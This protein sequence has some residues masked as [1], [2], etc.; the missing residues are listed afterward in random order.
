M[1]F[2]VASILRYQSLCLK[3]GRKEERTKESGTDG[4]SIGFVKQLQFLIR[5][6]K[7][8]TNR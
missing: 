1:F 5:M 6:N 2:L 4:T 8:L 3:A 7:R